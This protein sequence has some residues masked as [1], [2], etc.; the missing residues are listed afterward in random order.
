[1]TCNEIEELLSDLLDDELAAGA[2]T[3]VETHLASCEACA[4]SYKRLKRTVRFVRANAAGDFAPGT[5][6]SLYA[7]FT[8]ALVDAKFKQDQERILREEVFR[9][10]GGT[11]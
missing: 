3:G 8:R 7:R 2:R 9:S 4:R 1:M 6:G 10:E 11:Q 5:N